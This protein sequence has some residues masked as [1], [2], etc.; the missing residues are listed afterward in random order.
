MLSISDIQRLLRK[1]R[2]TRF[3]DQE[4]TSNFLRPSNQNVT[5]QARIRKIS[6][7]LEGET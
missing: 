2:M 4:G 5:G 6:V 7:H 3:R 1:E